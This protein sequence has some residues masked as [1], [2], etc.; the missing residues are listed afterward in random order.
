MALTTAQIENIQIDYGII[1]KDYGETTEELLGPTRGGGTLEITKELRD[2]ETDQSK[3]KSKGLQVIDSINAKLS[4][5]NLDTSIETLALA[6]PF[7]TLAGDGDTTPYTL[8]GETT[9]VGVIADSAYLTNITMFAKV[10]GGGYK[11]ITL[12]N[13]MNEAD[14]ELAAEPNAEGEVEAE[15]YAH[16]D[17][18]DDTADLFE[19]ADVDT[20]TTT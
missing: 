6:L 13:A 9:D 7:A 17:P 20:I 2:I 11:K 3:G 8:T 12:Y 5:N 16:W 1:Y 14:F 15:F 4:V 19:I 10:I 18:T